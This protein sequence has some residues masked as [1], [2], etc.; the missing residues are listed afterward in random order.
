MASRRFLTL[1]GLAAALVLIGPAATSWAHP[2]MHHGHAH[3]HGKAHVAHGHNGHGH[4][5]HGQGH[6]VGHSG[7]NHALSPNSAGTVRP[8]SATSYHSTSKAKG[9]GHAYGRTH[10]DLASHPGKSRGLFKHADQ[11]STR[12]NH[13]QHSSPPPVST[14]GGGGDLPIPTFNPQQPANGS[15]HPPASPSTP[16]NGNHAGSPPST[17]PPPAQPPPAAKRPA[18]L[19]QILFHSN[20]APFTVLPIV[21][22]SVLLLGVGGL[23]GLARHRA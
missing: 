13:P 11:P 1:V 3:A 9:R 4:H 7:G 15:N 12:V 23:I 2:G 22:I 20:A 10:N 8:A 14:S 19:A 18:A 21:V 16:H 6:H 17:G 5:A